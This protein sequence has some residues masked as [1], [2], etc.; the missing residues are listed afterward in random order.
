MKKAKLLI[1]VISLLLNLNT[2]S[3]SELRLESFAKVKD[4]KQNSELSLYASEQDQL[5]LK[6]P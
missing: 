4:L 1:Q 3:V 6:R 2:G 5:K